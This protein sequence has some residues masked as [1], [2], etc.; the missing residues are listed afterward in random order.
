MKIAV[1]PDAAMIIVSLV[2]KYGHEYLSS[3]NFSKDNSRHDNVTGEENFDESLPPFTM[4]GYDALKANKYTG[5]ETPSGFRGRLSLYENILENAEAAIIIGNPPKN[6][7]HMYNTLN[8]MIL[9]GCVS[10]NNQQQLL[11]KLLKDK[12]M[13]ILEVAYPQSCD[14]LIQ[15][16][17]RI[18]IFLK[19]LEKYK[20]KQYLFNEDNLT[21]D[22]K[23]NTKRIELEEFKKIV[24]KI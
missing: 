19:N 6:Y 2:N 10:C 13:P 4:T 24:N 18:K 12:Q 5:N 23:P 15:M 17:N 7:N 3:T 11:I 21:V 8:E 9:F 16:I 1:M 14:Q 20:G 22:L